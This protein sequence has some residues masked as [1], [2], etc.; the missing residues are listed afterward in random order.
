MTHIAPDRAPAD[1][2]LAGAARERRVVGVRRNG[3]RRDAETLLDAREPRRESRRVESGEAVRR[4]P[5]RERRRGRTERARPVDGGSA[6]D[7]TPGER[8]SAPALSR[9]D[10]FPE[11]ERPTGLVSLPS[12]V[13][14]S[15]PDKREAIDA[16]KW[17]VAEDFGVAPT[18]VLIRA[19]S[20][21]KTSSGKIRRGE[22]RTAFVAGT[23]D[24]VARG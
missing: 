23:L 17:A 2:E 5:V 15:D 24:E 3:P 16:I 1:A 4:L 22:T 8:I 12:T 11:S 19:G 20:A 9:D 18:V 7:A 14:I 10:A 6:A 21:Q 13:T